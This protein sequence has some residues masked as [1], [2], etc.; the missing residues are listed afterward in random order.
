[1]NT[2][3]SMVEPWPDSM[4]FEISRCIEAGATSPAV[5]LR[6]ISCGSSSE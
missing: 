2:M 1:M 4:T 3:C 5:A 6:K